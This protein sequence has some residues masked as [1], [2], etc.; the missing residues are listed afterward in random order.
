MNTGYTSLSDS[1]RKQRENLR[2]RMERV[3]LKAEL[4]TEPDRTLIKM[5]LDNNNSF[6]QIANLTGV[7]QSTVA[8][9][10][11][12]I[13]DRLCDTGIETTLK[14]QSRLTQKQKR[15]VRD[16]FI[17]GMNAKEIAHKHHLSYYNVTKTIN[18]VKKLTGKKHKTTIRNY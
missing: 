9:R 3:R 16:Y 6:R 1:G 11:K 12:K 8:R 17:R 14:K 5:Y 4:L 13:M 2:R 18:N 10:F 7:N 15:V